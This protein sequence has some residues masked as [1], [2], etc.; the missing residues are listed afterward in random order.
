MKHLSLVAQ[1]VEDSL[2][3]T[4]ARAYRD[5]LVALGQPCQLFDLYRTGFDPVLSAD[6]IG[7]RTAQRPV[8][9]DVARAQAAVLAADAMAVIYPLWWLAMPAMMK[10]YVDR[11][12]ARGFADEVRVGVARGLMNG[13]GKRMRVHRPHHARCRRCAFA[14][15]VRA[16]ASNCRST[17]PNAA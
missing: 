15:A 9:A 14:Q 17:I 1:P 7:P 12:L 4:L 5:E 6:E 3:M 2:T 16:K 13:K 8:A 11:V 10:R